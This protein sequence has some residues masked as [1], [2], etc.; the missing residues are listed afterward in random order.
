[1]GG[2]DWNGATYQGSHEPLVTVAC[3]EHVQKLVDARVGNKTRKVK[4][5]FAYTG[6]IRCGHCGCLMA[7]ELKKAGR[8]TITA[9]GI[10]GGALSPNTRQEVLMSGFSDTLRELVIPQQVLEWLGDAILDSDR[11]Q[12]AA[13]ESNVKRLQARFDQIKARIETMYLDKLD[14]RVTEDFFDQKAAEW[15]NEQ[16][17]LLT[18]IHDIQ[19]A[20]PAPV[21]QAIDMLRMTSRAAELFLEQSG[22]EQRRLLNTMVETASFKG[23]ELRTKLFEPFEILRHSN[24]KKHRKEN[25]NVTMDIRSSL[26]K[27]CARLTDVEHPLG[28]Q[29]VGFRTTPDSRR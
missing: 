5:D 22:V 18:K 20:T 28:I 13:R 7:G 23:G 3:W 29:S 14:G 9:L 21:D 12:R 1:M 4:H 11:T 15:R 10:A 17:D 8:C 6:L 27:R 2:F 25:E 19:R 26:V 24:H 16:D